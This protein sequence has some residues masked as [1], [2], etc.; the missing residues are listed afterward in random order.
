MNADDIRQLMTLYRIM[1]AEHIRDINLR[2]DCAQ[3]ALI[4]VWR[5]RQTNPGHPDAYYHKAARRRM[6][7]VAK[8]GF[9]TGM[10]SQQGGYVDPLRHRHKVFS[11]DAEL[12]ESGLTLMD[13]IHDYDRDREVP[14]AGNE[15]ARG[16]VSSTS[17]KPQERCN[18]GRHLMAET[19]GHRGGKGYCKA[20]ANEKRRTKRAERRL[21][22]L[23]TMR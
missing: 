8:T 9:M 20:C 13:Q 7:E 12:G 10:P 22:Q 3:E 21:T 18:S 16:G 19:R 2:E 5:L 23:A 1:A 6:R 4:H 11:L 15:K 17:F 14:C